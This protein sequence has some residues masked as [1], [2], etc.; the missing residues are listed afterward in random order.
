MSITPLWRT[1]LNFGAMS[2]ISSFGLF[3]ILYVKGINPLG[4]SSWLGAWIPVVFICIA[5]R[6][7]RDRIL[8]GFITYW[9]GFRTGML[10]AICGS[11][12][13][14]LFIYSF[15]KIY[16]TDIVE[17]FKNDA[18]QGM[19]DAKY[20]LGDDLYDQGM[21]SLEKI[22]IGT[23]ASND[24]FTKMLGAVLVCLITAAAYRK[25]PSPIDE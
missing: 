23:M 25:L 2:G 15:A 11:F 16:G 14:A 12:L 18:I 4:P 6:Y 22:T 20:I 10:T 19:E 1:A 5:T 7:Y 8:G 13:F 9:Q 24:F 3:L 21:E 17:L